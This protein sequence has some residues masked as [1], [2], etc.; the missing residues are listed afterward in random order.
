[1]N[2]TEKLR[3][4]ALNAAISYLV[5][6]RWAQK[7]MEPLQKIFDGLNAKY[8]GMFNDL[9]SEEDFKLR[10]RVAC[11][12]SEYFKAVNEKREEAYRLAYEYVKA[13]EPNFEAY[14]SGDF[15]FGEEDGLLCL[16]ANMDAYPMNYPINYE[17]GD[18]K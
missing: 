5:V 1:M 12:I 10:D 9:A 16:P 3:I 4:K 8:G 18:G 13:V 17:G 6:D 11:K 7:K 14:G 15:I 2:K